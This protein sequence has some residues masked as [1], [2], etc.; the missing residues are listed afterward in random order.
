MSIDPEKAVSGI[1]L[2]G[3]EV[4]LSPPTNAVL[5]TAQELS[6]EDQA[7]ARKNIGAAQLDE[8]GKVPEKQLP[9]SPKAVLYKEQELTEEEKTQAR[10]NIGAFSKG[11]GV[12]NGSFSVDTGQEVSVGLIPSGAKARIRGQKDTSTYSDVVFDQ[13]KLSY[14]RTVDGELSS[15]EIYGE[16][17]QPYQE[18]V[19]TQ[20]T[21]T[22]EKSIC[23]H[24]E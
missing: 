9:E 13:E 11:G 5:Y 14:E 20:T 12:V 8:N 22:K 18:L 24:Y 19:P 15:A 7:Q 4:P 16:H 17:N 21:P 1:L 2:D 10:D 6:E 3:A 23:W